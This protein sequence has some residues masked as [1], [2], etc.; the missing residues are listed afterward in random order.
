[1]RVFHINDNGPPRRPAL[2]RGLVVLGLVVV[3]ALL[4]VAVASAAYSITD[5][6]QWANVTNVW[7]NGDL[8]QQNSAYSE[9][10]FVPQRLTIDCT[11]AGTT[12][13]VDIQY[14]YKKSGKYAFDY[15]GNFVNSQGGTIAIIAGP[16]YD[17]DIGADTVEAEVTVQF[18]CSAV[19][20][21]VLTFGAHIS[22]V[23]PGA[24]E[25]NGSPYHV[26]VGG[27]DNQMQSG[28]VVGLLPEIRICKDV[29][30]QV[31]TDHVFHF[32]KKVVPG[33]S[34][35]VEF[36]LQDTDCLSFEGLPANG[37]ATFLEL[38]D[39]DLYGTSDFIFRRVVCVQ[40]AGL[41]TVTW[42]PTSDGN[43]IGVNVDIDSDTDRAVCTFYNAPSTAV[44]LA[45]FT[46][47]AAGRQVRLEWQAG[48]ETNNAGYN[49]LRARS[50]AG[51]YVK[52]NPQLI[53][54]TGDAVAGAAYSFVDRPGFGVFFYK[55]E[56]V[57]MSGI[58]TAHGPVQVKVVWPFLRLPFQPAPPAQ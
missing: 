39:T 48:T 44:K 35:P 14:A 40:T 47:Q 57:D 24:S 26:R 32:T 45:S 10:D 38:Y 17:P 1:M 23:D 33:D 21:A 43:G 4:A 53:G 34:Q 58:A 55:L 11:T 41:G 54:A 7:T 52:V 2:P 25:I 20:Q 8:N 36:T 15:L 3:L 49:I 50:I 12:E 31:P 28:A 46:G 27:R 18:S 5:F 30:G 13:T 9:G 22:L 56:D 51:P 37:N 6:D 29:L 42:A 16:T 19:G